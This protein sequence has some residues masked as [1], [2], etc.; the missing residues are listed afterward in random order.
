MRVHDRDA[1]LEVDNKFEK[2]TQEDQECKCI[3]F[4]LIKRFPLGP[5]DVTFLQNQKPHSLG[6]IILTGGKN[7][8]DIRKG[9]G[10]LEQKLESV[11]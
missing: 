5:P 7:L 10:V 8:E 11:L 9:L 2:E 6:K 1:K 3:G 4:G